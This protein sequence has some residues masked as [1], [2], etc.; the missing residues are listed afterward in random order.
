MTN[1]NYL[2]D[3]TTHRKGI[4]IYN[5]FGKLFLIIYIRI[6]IKLNSG[7]AIGSQIVSLYYPV[8]V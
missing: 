7:T 5:N 2:T 1:M 4:T 6:G 8:L 3:A